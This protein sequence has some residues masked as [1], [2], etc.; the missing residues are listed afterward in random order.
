MAPLGGR[1][2]SGRW[3]L[4]LAAGLLLL[5]VPG[6]GANLYQL[7]SHWVDDTSHAL[8]LSRFRGSVSVVSMAYGACTRI[9]S[10]TLRRLEQLQQLADA[11]GLDLQFVLVGLDPRTDTPEAW[12]SY[13]RSHHLERSNWTFLSGDPGATRL[14]ASLLGIDYWLYDDHVLHDFGIALVGPDGEIRRRMHWQDERLEGFLEG[15][16]ARGPAAV[17][18]AH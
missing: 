7:S 12:R 9:C 1:V 8:Q 2:S 4:A 11:R 17:L 14:V 3:R 18:G 5:S 13:R 15:V 10:T 6:Q 16:P